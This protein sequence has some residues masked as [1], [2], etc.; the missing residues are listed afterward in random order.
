MA[1][2]NNV[3]QLKKL[4]A[5]MTNKT[6]EQISGTTIADVLD[7]IQTNYT[8]GGGGGG[9]TITNLTLN[10]NS[11]YGVNNGTITMSDGTTIF[12]NIAFIEPLTLTSTEGSAKAKTVV[13]VTPELTEGNS[14]RISAGSETIIP[15][16]GEDLTA[17][18]SWNGTDEIEAQNG[19]KLRVA[20]CD[21]NNKAVKCGIVSVK[22]PIF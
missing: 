7:V 2:Q 18:D 22:S 6:A 1:E 14:Y 20:E 19:V 21:A 10:V 17:W 3:L 4:A 13:T 12:V 5:K 15:A 8:G 16:T 11:D 9:A